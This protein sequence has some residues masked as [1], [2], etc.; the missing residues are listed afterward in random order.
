MSMLAAAAPDIATPIGPATG[1]TRLFS[2]RTLPLLAARL[3]VAVARAWGKPFRL[4]NVVVAATHGEVCEV[5]G[6]DLDFVLRPVDGPRFDQIGYHFILGM[7]RSGELI[8]ERHALYAALAKVDTAPIRR[9][10]AQ[11][12]VDRLSAAPSRSIDV[13]QDYAR[14]I[15]AATARA[16]FGI[17]PPDHAQFMDAARAIFGHCFLNVTGDKVVAARAIAAAQ[18]MTGWFDAEIARRRE[19][20]K[21]GEDMMGNLL[22]AGAG[23]D[24]TRRSLGGMLVGS[25][26]TTATV[27]AKVLTVLMNDRDLLA[28]ATRDRGEPARL[29]GWCQEAL[30]R[31]PHAPI[32]ARQAAVETTLRGVTVPAGG[33]V[34]LWI[35]AAMYDATAFPDP[36]RSRPDRDLGAYLHLGGGLHPCAGRAINAWQI[37]MLVAG[38]LDLEPARL[39]RLQWAGPFPAHLPLTWKDRAR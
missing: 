6:R 3:G 31:W 1:V 14:P 35:Q 23:D 8:G 28:S 33:K 18:L 7:D 29:Y 2:F 17:D 21:M 26:D 11:D 15:A 10:A 22:R 4:G 13:V 27:V 24:L 30:R 34:I 19:S 38:L 5:M 36:A 32:L 37:P 39:G 20:G 16:V 12:I 9:A 25:I